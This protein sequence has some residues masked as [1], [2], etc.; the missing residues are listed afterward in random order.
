VLKPGDARKFTGTV[1]A[2]PRAGVSV[3]SDVDDTIKLSDVLDHR[4]MLRRTFLEPFQA[5][6][7]MAEVYRVWATNGVAFHYVSASPWQLFQPLR[8]FAGTNGFPQGSWS[9]KQWRLK[10]RSFKSLFEK[11]ERYK[12]ETL[13]PLLRQFPGRRF[14]LVG[15]SGE[16]D[17]EAYATLA[18]EFPAQVKAIFIRDVTGQGMEAERYRTNFSGL[19][20]GL[21]RV[22]TEP[23]E[24]GRVEFLGV[25]PTSEAEK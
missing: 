18:R 7:G 25:P 22:F 16:R 4:A 14:V 3:I 12:V 1:L 13:A 6:P 5:V 20:G 2:L 17:P 23:S 8:E 11:P 15:D 10:D 21:W 9:M 19:P 24:I